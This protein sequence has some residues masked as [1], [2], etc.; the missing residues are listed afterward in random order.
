MDRITYNPQKNKQKFKRRLRQ[1]LQ[2]KAPM[3][4]AS[5]T[6][7][8]SSLKFGSLNVNGL[9]LEATWAVHQLLDKRGF[10]VS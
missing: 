3:T 5:S 1:K 10:D 2:A 9:D 6:G 7:Q 8:T 4:F